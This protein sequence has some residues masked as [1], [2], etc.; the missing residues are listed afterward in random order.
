M[1]ESDQPARILL[2]DDEDYLRNGVKRILQIEGF[3][4]DT[5]EN[6]GEGI[7]KGT[8]SDFDIALLDLKM[9]DM[10]GIEVLRSIRE[11]RPN[12]I[13][14]MA[15]AYA[16]YETAVEATKLGA[17]GY[18]LKPF[19]PDELIHNIEK[20]MQK[21]RLILEAERLRLEREARLL[22]LAFE[23]SRLNTIINLLADGVLVMN[24]FG[25]MV[26]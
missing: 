11:K 20:G 12:T 8:E 3:E 14:F 22:E 24:Q 17:E 21:R 26:Y 15:T 1:D 2:V 9:P 10:S 4:V 18:I 16:S 5:A 19:T 23:R 7:R 6:G 13:C 25:E